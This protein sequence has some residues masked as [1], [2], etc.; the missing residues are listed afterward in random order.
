[1]DEALTSVPGLVS[2]TPTAVM[3][4]SAAGS[5]E[6]GH[7]RFDGKFEPGSSLAQPWGSR[8]GSRG[9]SFATVVRDLQPVDGRL[10]EPGYCGIL[11]SAGASGATV[12]WKDFTETARAILEDTSSTGIHWIHHIRSHN[13]MR[14]VCFA[15]GAGKSGP[16]DAASA[17][18]A[19][20]QPSQHFGSAGGTGCSCQV[21]SEG[22]RLGRSHCRAGLPTAVAKPIIFSKPE[23]GRCIGFSCS[24][25]CLP[26]R[27]RGIFPSCSV[28]QVAQQ[29]RSSVGCEIFVFPCTC[30]V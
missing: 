15:E 13:T 6:K 14:L 8:G 29:C 19:C 2:G 28:L 27:V 10:G 21:S 5:P 12:F 20:L 25:W 16:A 11:A 30:D 9:W 3:L 17:D 24:C 7:R 4:A 18:A 26:R 22:T 23:P 1:M